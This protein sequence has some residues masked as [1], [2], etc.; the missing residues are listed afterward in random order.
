MTLS[1]PLVGLTYY[2]TRTRSI[3][4]CTRPADSR[5]HIQYALVAMVTRPSHPPDLGI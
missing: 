4:T 2:R 1:S 5:S 3:A